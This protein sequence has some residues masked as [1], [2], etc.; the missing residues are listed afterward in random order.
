VERRQSMQIE[1]V[2]TSLADVGEVKALWGDGEVMKFV[3]FAQGLK[4][5]DAEMTE[6]LDWIEKGRPQRNHYSIYE[7]GKYCGESFYN[8]DPETNSAALDIKLNAFARGRGI[9][10]Y[11]LLYAIEQAFENG[12][13][14]VWVNPNPENADAL[15]LYG[16]IGMEQKEIPPELYDPDYTQLY[17]ELRKNR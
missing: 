14:R 6:W 12:A 2:E 3:G 15:A 4:K 5:T 8:I 13:E 17:F 11:S 16:R 1:I 9:A 7:N 10:A